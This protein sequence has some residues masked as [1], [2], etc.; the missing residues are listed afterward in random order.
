MKRR[1]S[2]GQG[3]AGFSSSTMLLV[4]NSSTGRR[5]ATTLGL[6][7]ISIQQ[8][9]YPDSEVDLNFSKNL[10]EKEIIIFFQFD[11]TISLDAQL[12]N[13][14]AVLDHLKNRSLS[15]VMP[16]IPYLRSVH[17]GVE[18]RFNKLGFVITSIQKAVKNLFVVQP[19]C[20][21]EE[22]SRVVGT[23]FFRVIS[24]DAVLGQFLSKE[25]DDFVIVSP[26]D[27]FQNMAAR[28]GKVAQANVVTI[29]KHRESPEKV[30]VSGHQG[31]LE[32]SLSKRF[33]IVDDI[34]STGDT[35]LKTINYL[36]QQGVD[37]ISCVVV[38]SLVQRQKVIDLLHQNSIQY[39][40]SNTLIHQNAAIDV[41][42]SIAETL[43]DVQFS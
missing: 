39:F 30:V 27:G 5:L 20:S 37:Q 7:H 41:T 11:P 31:P 16:Y 36:R 38:H 33:V 1:T 4:S 42:A 43:R 35:L 18:G 17:A 29:D 13:L 14:L 28:L 24:I 6:E 15:L 32:R 34:A 3:S 10:S 26:D 12:L 22:L 2:A 40:F 23:S 25:F 21:Q 9:Q 8:T 19:H